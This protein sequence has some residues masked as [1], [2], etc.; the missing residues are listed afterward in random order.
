MMGY[1]DYDYVGHL[2]LKM[3]LISGNARVAITSTNEIGQMTEEAVM[4]NWMNNV[5]RRII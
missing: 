5:N 3:Y 4:H 1:C 2:H